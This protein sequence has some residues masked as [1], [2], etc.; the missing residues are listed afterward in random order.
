[1]TEQGA[2]GDEALAKVVAAGI[3]A[4]GIE[5]A[6]AAG[7]AVH[8]RCYPTFWGGRWNFTCGAPAISAKV[9]SGESAAHRAHV[10]A[11]LLPVVTQAQAEAL[12]EFVANIEQNHQFPV[13]PGVPLRSD[14]GYVSMTT[15][16]ALVRARADE[17]GDV[18]NGYDPEPQ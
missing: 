10:A 18:L 15:L 8:A 13:P 14:N 6:L 4:A 12:R 3:E 11:A 17:G 2:S 7:L 1:M 9:V 5:A 16:R